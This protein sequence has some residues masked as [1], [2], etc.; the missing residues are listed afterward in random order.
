LNAWI[1]KAWR[2]YVLKETSMLIM[3]HDEKAVLPDGFVRSEG[4]IDISKK[5]LAEAHV[6]RWVLV[7]GLVPRRLD[8][9]A[10]AISERFHE[11]DEPTEEAA[12]GLEITR[13]DEAVGGKGWTRGR[14]LADVPIE[15]I[16]WAD[17]LS[18]KAVATVLDPSEA[19]G[20]R[21]VVIVDGPSDPGLVEAILDGRTRIESEMVIQ[22]AERS[23]R[24]DE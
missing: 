15:G 7:V 16:D 20:L 22:D 10:Q 8:G 12:A 5:V 13:L 3:E 9:E 6:V 23:P 24:V 21:E 1:A 2:G 19:Q 17:A 11:I 14:V 18:A 4:F